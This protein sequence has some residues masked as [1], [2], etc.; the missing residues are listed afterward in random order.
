VTLEAP[1]PHG[2]DK[3][4]LA[5]WRDDVVAMS[6]AVGWPAPQLG[7]RRHARGSTLSFTAPAAVLMSATSVNEWALERAA[8]HA[9]V[10]FDATELEATRLPLDP[11]D[12]LV[13]LRTLVAAEADT[14]PADAAP[15]KDRAIPIVLVTGSNGKTTTARLLA[16]MLRQQGHTVGLCSTDGVFVGDETIETGDWSGPVGARRVLGD[17]RV[18]AAVLETARGGLLRR[19]LVVPRADVAVVTNV[20]ADHFGEYG[21]HALADIAELK[22]SLAYGLHAGGTLVLNGDD[23]LLDPAAPTA[24]LHAAARALPADRR[25]TFSLERSWPTTLPP[26]DE[27]PIT[28][29]GAARFNVANALAAATAAQALGIPA[30]DIAAALRAFGTDPRDNVGR[31]MQLPLGGALVVVDYAHNPHGMRALLTTARAMSAGRLLLLLGQAGDRDDDAIR[32]LAR[33]AWAAGPAIVVLKELDG[34]RRG[35]APGAVPTLL[36]DELARAGAT[37]AQ[38]TTVLDELDAVRALLAQARRDDLVVLPVHALETRTRVLAL[39][40]RLR[41]MAWQA[42][43]PVP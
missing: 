30:G 20:A 33:T 1:L 36:A 14:P 42:G 3:A 19:G 17:A 24:R 26:I 37:P 12:A 22:S 21:I 4:V 43:D 25:V 15:I 40:D 31:L 38:L 27:I 6:A 11:A 35:R 41:A 23:P 39:L 13:A 2:H 5:G 8:V 32:A 9:A 34:Y 18:T 7:V 29:R 28:V 16:A 10:A